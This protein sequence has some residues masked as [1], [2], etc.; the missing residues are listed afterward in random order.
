[1]DNGTEFIRKRLT[2][3]KLKNKKKIKNQFSQYLNFYI[4]TMY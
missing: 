2:S 3:R 4:F 1:M